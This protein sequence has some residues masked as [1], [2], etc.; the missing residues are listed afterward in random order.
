[1]DRI[2]A[3][4]MSSVPLRIAAVFLV[5]LLFCLMRM[6][7]VTPDAPSS[8]NFN[9]AAAWRVRVLR[10][11]QL[12]NSRGQFYR[13]WSELRKRNSREWSRQIARVIQPFADRQSSRL[14]LHFDQVHPGSLTHD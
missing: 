2:I 13:K 3:F 6:R 11:P 8:W 10:N 4:V 9:K 14:M 1:M 12:L 7:A 5:A